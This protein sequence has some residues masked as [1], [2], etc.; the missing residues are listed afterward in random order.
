MKNTASTHEIAA[1]LVAYTHKLDFTAARNALY[2]DNVVSHEPGSEAITGLAALAAKERHWQDS[3]ETLHGVSCSEP[4][5]A[6]PFISIAMTWDITY[7]GQAR[8]GWEE[9]ALFEVAGGKVVAERFF[10]RFD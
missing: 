5:I 2:A 8:S 4:L 6:G 7:R 1:Q 9:I 10:Y 3:I